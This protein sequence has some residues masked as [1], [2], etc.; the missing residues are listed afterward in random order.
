MPTQRLKELAFSLL[1]VGTL[2]ALRTPAGAA[3]AT[4]VAPLCP[5]GWTCNPIGSGI[6]WMVRDA[7]VPSGVGRVNAVDIA[8]GAAV[9]RVVESVNFPNGY[10]TVTDM[11]VR[12]QATVAINGGFFKYVQPPKYGFSSVLK[13]AGMPL[14]PN[15]FATTV[16]A[17]GMSWNG[18]TYGIAMVPPAPGNSDPLAA[19]GDAVGAG[20]LF[21]SAGIPSVSTAYDWGSLVCGSH[22]RSAAWLLSNGHLML[23]TF[24]G[25]PASGF[26]ADQNGFWL[27]TATS[28]FCQK[29]KW[30]GNG[31]PFNGTSLGQFI[32]A[33]FKETVQAMD[34]DGGGSTTFVINGQ[35]RNQPSNGSPRPV[36]DGIMVFSR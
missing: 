26:S 17:L 11:A 24:D 1:L 3:P 6:S 13:I 14:A 34:L 7:S 20:P 33:N 22:P 8:P 15:A 35:L 16:P 10:E 21:I 30:D 18:G 28:A 2:G 5:T 29:F 25:V 9:V 19:Y 36:A 31:A 12:T 27:D 23:G 32:M 4:P